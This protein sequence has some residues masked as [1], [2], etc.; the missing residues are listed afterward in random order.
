[1]FLL[2]ALSTFL[3]NSQASVNS[4]NDQTQT[5]FNFPTFSPQSCSNGDLICMGSVTASNGHLSLTPEP[6]QGNSSSSS[7]S[8]LYKVGRVLYRYPVRAWPAFIS[9][10]FTVRISAFP[11]S[12]GSGD[13]MAFVFAQDSGPSPPDS[14]GSFLGLLNRSTQ[15]G[16]VKQLGIELDTFMNQEFDPDGNH[17]AIDTTSIM[18]PVV[19]KSL[20]ST[21]ID[22]KSG[23]DIKFRIDYD[24]WNQILQV[25]AGYSENPTISFLNYSI[26]MSQMV[27]SS[28]YVGFTASTGT[29]PESHQV[30]DWVFTSVQLPGIPLTKP[31]SDKKV[32][33]WNAKSIWVVDLPIFLGMAILIACTYPL[34]LRVLRRNQCIGNQDEDDIESQSRTA[35]NAPEMFTYKQLSV[36]TQNFCKENLLGS[37]GFGIVYKGIISSDPPKTIAVKKISATSK[38]V[39]HVWNSYTKNALL[40]CVDQ[41]LDGKFEEEQVRRTLIV[42]L[43][44]LHTYCMLRPK[45]RKVV[46]ILLNPNEPLMELPDTRARPSAV[47]LSVS[48]SAPTTEFGSTSSSKDCSPCT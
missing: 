34:I 25:S 17:I 12:T 48:S 11:N 14:Y 6:E 42:G 27:P 3:I 35:A 19:A 9:T 8:P 29:L 44:C 45:M 22:L 33:H 38:Q 1:M 4:M 21:G 15:G 47:Y 41:M 46:Q 30:L 10:T 23:R 20:N 43:A 26:D 2:L 16:A 39:E 13:G 28:V 36:A 7:S 24:G 40:D 32:H 37:G 5:T 18:N 31:G